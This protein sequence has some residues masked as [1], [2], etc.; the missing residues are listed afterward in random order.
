M[1][2]V[3]Q[4]DLEN[5][6]NE[7]S[8][9]SS[10]L[11]ANGKIFK[12]LT[13]KLD[14]LNE[15][16]EDFASILKKAIVHKIWLGFLNPHTGKICS[17]VHHKDDGSIDHGVSFKL[18]LSAGQKQGGLGI[19]DLNMIENVMRSD[20]RT[21]QLALPLLLDSKEIEQ[22]NQIRQEQGES[23]LLRINKTKSAILNTVHNAPPEFLQL[24]QK[25]LPIEFAGRLASS[26]N[27]NF[28]TSEQIEVLGEL[29]KITNNDCDKQEIIEQVAELLETDYIKSVRLNFSDPHDTALRL[30]NTWDKEVVRQIAQELNDLIEEEDN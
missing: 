9:Q 16:S 10:D 23:P 12:Q 20:P 17:F 25:G 18:W 30:F 13:D 22:A 27:K 15:V 28:N 8:E 24:V 7:Q 4:L 11:G 3:Q 19:R 29:R 1:G 26:Y 2:K 6:D 21:Y 14:E 5:V